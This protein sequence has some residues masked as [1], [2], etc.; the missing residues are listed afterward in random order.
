MYDWPELR[1]ATDAFWQGVARHLGVSFPLT[2]RADYTATWS[3]PTLL[4]GQTCGYPFTH[5]FRHRVRY[6]ATP[7]YRA[8]GCRGP[9]Y[10]S[11]V[12]AREAAPLSAF[13]GKQ[14]V[15]NNPDSM[16][17][18][19][20]LKLV[21]APLASNGEFFAATHESGSHLQSLLAVRDGVADV[22]AIDAV[23]VALARRV[24]P[25]LLQGL[26][27]IARSPHVPALP[28]ISNTGDVADIRAALRKAFAD[29]TLAAAREAL[30]LEDVEVLPEQAYD[31]ILDLEQAMEAAG[32]INLA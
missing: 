7:H 4:L 32:G 26:H 21:F 31:R 17:G 9:N 29:P 2:R 12:F 25:D 27:E 3:D 14:A 15:I 18:M 24:R 11:I 10:S 22:C 19:L 6:V 28:F 16:S 5:A 13:R 23:C 1:E 20:A 30:L 8:D